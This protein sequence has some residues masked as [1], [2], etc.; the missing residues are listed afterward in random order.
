MC[1][2]DLCAGLSLPLQPALIA[3]I[4]FCISRVIAL[5]TLPEDIFLCAFCKWSFSE[6]LLRPAFLPQMGHTFIAGLL[7]C[8]SMEIFPC[9]FLSRSSKTLANPSLGCARRWTF[10]SMFHA[11]RRVQFLKKKRENYAMMTKSR[12]INKGKLQSFYPYRCHF[13]IDRP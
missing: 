7:C 8:H 9:S 5:S 3:S 10:F 11:S 13:W 1:D 12:T 6:L 4:A 2:C